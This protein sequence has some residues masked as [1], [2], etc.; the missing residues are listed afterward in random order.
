[1][2]LA[3]APPQSSFGPILVRER[4]TDPAATS[5]PSPTS[6]SSITTAPM[7]MSARLWIFAPWIVT[8]CPMETSSPISI[9]DF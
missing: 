6:A 2:N 4:T 8:L 1:M 5:A 7:P 9:V 3:G